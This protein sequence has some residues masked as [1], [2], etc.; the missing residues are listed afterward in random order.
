MGAGEIIVN[1]IDRD[2]TFSGYELDIS[3]KISNAVS[4]PVVI[5]GG[6]RSISDFSEAVKSGV[7]AVSAGSMFVY[8]GIH[9]AVLIN[10]PSQEE[11]DK[12]L[13]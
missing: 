1:S 10:Y 2:G 11:L 8:T 9:K 4:I 6:A 3:N 13:S 12:F 7:D 5:S